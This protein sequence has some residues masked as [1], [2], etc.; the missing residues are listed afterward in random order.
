MLLTSGSTFASVLMHTVLLIHIVTMFRIQPFLKNR[1]FGSVFR[2]I[3][4]SAILI[5]FYLLH[6]V[7]R[8]LYF[9]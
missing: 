5:S 2:P 1:A 3:E 9:R 7:E 6:L 4:T 8:N